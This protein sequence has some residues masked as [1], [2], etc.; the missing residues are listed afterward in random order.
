[1]QNLP[2]YISLVFILTAACTLLL[3]V[4]VLN[5]SGLRSKA[6][7]QIAFGLLAWVAVQSIV[8]WKNVYSSNLNQFPPKILLFGILPTV[9]LLIVLFNTAKGKRFVDSLTLQ[10]LTYLNIIRIPVE[11]VLYWL[12]VQKLI[13]QLMTFDGR[14]FDILAGIAAPIV[15]CLAF[16]KQS[17]NK[18]LLLTYNIIS[19]CLLANI[20]VNALLSVPTPV[21]QFGFNQPNIGLLYFPFSLLPTFIVPVVLFGH[22]VSMR[23]LLKN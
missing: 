21:Q 19:L 2:L 16:R 18:K 13:P 7:W 4:N 15:G 17:I 23:Q 11:I 20:I 10:P 14:N 12:F 3:F 1:M 22:V 5:K 9:I 8:S 6:K